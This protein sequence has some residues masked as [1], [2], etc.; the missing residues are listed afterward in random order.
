MEP[1]FSCFSG[2]RWS[3]LW[4]KYKEEQRNRVKKMTAPKKPKAKKTTSNVCTCCVENTIIVTCSCCTT[5]SI[6]WVVCCMTPK[7]SVEWSER[8]SPLQ[9]R[10]NCHLRQ[11]MMKY[12][13]KE[14]NSFS[15]TKFL[16]I[17]VNSV[18]SL[19]TSGPKQYRTASLQNWILGANWQAHTAN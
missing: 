4:A 19:C 12:W 16:C 13:R 15:M 7:R 6:I 3:D 11:L 8:V 9:K 18:R 10:L 2:A 1:L 17:H 5:C 14:K